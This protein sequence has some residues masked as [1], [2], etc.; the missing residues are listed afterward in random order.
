MT[1]EDIRGLRAIASDLES[2]RDTNEVCTFIDVAVAELT[3]FCDKKELEIRRK[4]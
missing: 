4:E 1:L 2:G 3:E